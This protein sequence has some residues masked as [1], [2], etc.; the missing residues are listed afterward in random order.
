DG[1]LRGKVRY[2]A[3]E[4]VSRAEVDR[5]VDVYA[6]AVVLWEL[7][8][9]R[10]WID[11][12]TGDP[13]AAIRMVKTR[14]LEPPSASAPDVPAALDDVV[15]RADARRLLSA[16]RDAA[17]HDAEARAAAA[18]REMRSAVD[19]R[20]R[21]PRAEARVPVRASPALAAAAV[22]SALVFSAVDAAA[23]PPDRA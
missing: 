8:A 6:A 22:V 5:R 1:D 20:S 2:L 9:G 15:L 21:H 18:A 12:P 13:A 17:D 7:L 14:A 11:A 16:D 3:P 10:R 19:A 23:D 4:Q